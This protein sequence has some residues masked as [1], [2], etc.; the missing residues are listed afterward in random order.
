ME[1][2]TLNLTY[3]SGETISVQVTSYELKFKSALLSDENGIYKLGTF[4][5]NSAAYKT[6]QP[7]KSIVYK[8]GECTVLAEYPPVKTPRTITYRVRS[9]WPH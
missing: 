1:I 5:I 3:V 8:V 4:K 9:D 2:P 6:W 7:I